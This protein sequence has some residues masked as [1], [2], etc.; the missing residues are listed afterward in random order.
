MCQHNTWWGCDRQ[1]SSF[2]EKGIFFWTDYPHLMILLKLWWLWI[3]FLDMEKSMRPWLQID[4]WTWGPFHEHFF[5]H[6][7]N[8]IEISFCSHLDSLSIIG[9]MF[10]MWQ[11]SISLMAMEEITPKWVLTLNLNSDGKKIN[12]ISPDCKQWSFEHDKTL[13]I[14]VWKYEWHHDKITFKRIQGYQV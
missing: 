2:G 5:H 13:S 7:S 10:C 6:C 4:R 12:E 3:A 14:H 8:L 9:I 11:G 1:T